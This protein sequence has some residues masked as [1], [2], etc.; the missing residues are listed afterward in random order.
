M[1]QHIQNVTAEEREHT[2]VSLFQSLFKTIIRRAH[3]EALDELIV[4]VAYDV[5]EKQTPAYEFLKHLSNQK[6]D[7]A[8]ML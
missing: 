1:G 2:E 5:H 7:T 8:S 4:T 6:R 3:H